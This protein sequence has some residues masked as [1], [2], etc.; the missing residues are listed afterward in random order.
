MRKFMTRLTAA[1]TVALAAVPALGLLQNAHAAEPTATISLVGLNL[2]N[3]AQAAEFAARVEAAG[4]Q[5]CSA[6]ARTNPGTDFT[7]AGCKVAVREQAAR[8]LSKS[9]RQ[10][11]RVAIR[12]TPLAIATR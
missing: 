8:Q 6:K 11:L 3:P 9:Q 10:G 2:S 5:V 1:A 4:E 7:M 12:S